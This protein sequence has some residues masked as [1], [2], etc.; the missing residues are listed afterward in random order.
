MKVFIVTTIKTF[1]NSQFFGDILLI[2]Q[3]EKKARIVKNQVKERRP[4][5]GLDYSRLTTFDD[6][7]YFQRDLE[8]IIQIKE[9]DYE[10]ISEATSE[11]GGESLP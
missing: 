11:T 4:Y 10:R 7:M 1:P 9:T 3:D 8:E 5:P 6:V 2:T